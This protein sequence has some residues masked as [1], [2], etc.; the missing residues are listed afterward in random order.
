MAARKLAWQVG[1]LLHGVGVSPLIGQ[2]GGC[3][4]SAD[5]ESLPAAEVLADGLVVEQHHVAGGFGELGGL[6]ELAFVG[7]VI[8]D[9]YKLTKKYNEVARQTT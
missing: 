6:G 7:W 4:H 8:Y 3:L 2:E 5:V 9:V 1:V